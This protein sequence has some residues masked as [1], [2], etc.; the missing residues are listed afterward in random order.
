MK[1]LLCTALVLCAVWAVSASAVGGVVVDDFNT[2]NVNYAGPNNSFE[3]TPT[4]TGSM[5]GNRATLL[6]LQGT[7]LEVN[8]PGGFDT[9]GVLAFSN[10]VGVQGTLAM[11]WDALP[12]GVDLTNAGADN[13]IEFVF[14]NSDQPATLIVDVTDDNAG[15]DVQVVPVPTGLSFGL[16][17]L[18][19]SFTGVDFTKVTTVTLNL[20]P[21]NAFGGDYAIDLLQSTFVDPVPEPAGLL[22]LAGGLL[23]LKARKRR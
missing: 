22:L 8:D 20:T 14:L 7:S 17:V 15:N 5:G 1:A 13:A 16:P 3:P 9:T 11:Q 2:G 19:S 21:D 6:D 18:F 23:G 10:D 12:P 4:V